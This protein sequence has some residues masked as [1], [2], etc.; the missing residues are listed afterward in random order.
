MRFFPGFFRSFFPET[1]KN[2]GPDESEYIDQASLL[3]AYGREGFD[4]IVTTYL[5]DKNKQTLPG[6]LRWGFIA[7]SA[8][9]LRLSEW[10]G[11][12]LGA[13]A[14]TRLSWLSRWALNFAISISVTH[15]WRIMLVSWMLDGPLERMMSKRALQDSTVALFGA[16]AF[17]ALMLYGDSWRHSGSDVPYQLLAALALVTFLSMKETALLFFPGFIVAMEFM[18]HRLGLPLYQTRDLYVISAAAGWWFVGW[19]LVR[20]ARWS[21]RELWQL[22]KVQLTA[23]DHPYSCMFQSGPPQRL[24]ADLAL[25]SPLPLCGALVFCR[26]SPELSIAV[27]VSLAMHAAMRFKN[28][29]TVLL[30]DV[31]MRLVTALGLLSLSWPW[32][33]LCTALIVLF[34]SWSYRKVRDVYDPVSANLCG[35]LRMIPKSAG[36]VQP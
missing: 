10:C 26:V 28:V 19:T 36:W 23:H 9:S 21:P 6:P 5:S 1:P 22:A 15:G 29:R 33:V 24:L 30:C 12:E 3:N 11:T 14:L 7:L 31:G 34:D 16:G 27:L 35:A 2:I 4:E 17:G 8:L 25:L 32:T 20:G 13:S 18:R